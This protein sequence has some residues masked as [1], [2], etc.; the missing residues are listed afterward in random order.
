M[1]VPRP[2]KQTVNNTVVITIIAFFTTLTQLYF[3]NLHDTRDAAMKLQ[4][5]LQRHNEQASMRLDI[6]K[7]HNEFEEYKMRH[8]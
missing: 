1:K 5:Q 3:D 4:I 8:P 7:Y 6:E 2:G